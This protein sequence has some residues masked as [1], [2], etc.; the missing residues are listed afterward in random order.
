MLGHNLVLF[1]KKTFFTVCMN[2]RNRGNVK[3]I[4]FEP[5]IP[6][7]APD[8]E[9]QIQEEIKNIKVS[10][11]DKPSTTAQSEKELVQQMKGLFAPKTFQKNKEFNFERDSFVLNL[12]N[13]F[14]NCSLLVFEDNSLGIKMDGVIYEVDYSY[15]GD[16]SIVEVSDSIKKLNSCDFILTAY[17]FPKSDI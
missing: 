12:P 1:F 11:Y 6:Q 7:S 8:I 2:R 13:T 9:K 5:K 14:E 15:I 3:K 16:G 17:N 4:E 10:E